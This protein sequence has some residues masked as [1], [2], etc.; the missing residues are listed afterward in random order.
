MSNEIP[1]FY[2]L[3]YIASSSTTDTPMPSASASTSLTFK[4]YDDFLEYKLWSPEWIK[5]PP[6]DSTSWTPWNPQPEN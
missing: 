2:P 4:P 1:E 3:S 6:P 5:G